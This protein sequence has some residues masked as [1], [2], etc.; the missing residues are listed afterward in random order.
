M[1]V[2]LTAALVLHHIEGVCKP[3]SRATLQREWLQERF[4]EFVAQRD[5]Q[6]AIE[7]AREQGET[8]RQAALER[9]EAVRQAKADR[10]T[11]RPS[12]L[13]QGRSPQAVEAPKPRDEWQQSDV[14]DE[15]YEHH[16]REG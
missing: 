16:Y 11:R 8:R 6:A 5:T 4:M 7:R 2:L 9:A 1:L 14:R 13:A 3:K 15:H 10:N 12:G